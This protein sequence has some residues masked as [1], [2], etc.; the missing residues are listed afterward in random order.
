MQWAWWA[1]GLCGTAIAGA[2]WRHRSR[3]QVKAV[4]PQPTVRLV[5]LE[6]ESQRLTVRFLTDAI[7]GLNGIHCR[8]IE[9][10][11]SYRRADSLMRQAQGDS[12]LETHLFFLSAN[13]TTTRIELSDGQGRF[14]LLVPADTSQSHRI[15]L[16]A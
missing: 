4:A 15:R 12:I 11:G 3:R 10:D 5:G 2:I 14:E 7:T 13:L 16:S 6:Q 8:L 1:A 9:P